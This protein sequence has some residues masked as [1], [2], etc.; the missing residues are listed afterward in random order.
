M[1]FAAGYKPKA[2]V[3]CLQPTDGKLYISD[4]L[5]RL[6]IEERNANLPIFIPT[7]TAHW[8]SPQWKTDT[9]PGNLLVLQSFNN[10]TIGTCWKGIFATSYFSMSLYIVLNLSFNTFFFRHWSLICQ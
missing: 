1:T 3:L 10:C 6:S 4:G 7:K 8:N 2:Y 5:R 9:C